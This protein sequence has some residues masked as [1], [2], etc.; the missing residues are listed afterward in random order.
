MDWASKVT[1]DKLC[2]FALCWRQGAS[3]DMTSRRSCGVMWGQVGRTMDT[4]KEI[5]I[6]SIFI[7]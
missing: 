1:A 5:G 4:I 6:I 2:V 3:V 7:K